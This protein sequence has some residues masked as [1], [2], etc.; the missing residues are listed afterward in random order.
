MCSNAN[1]K[2]ELEF[3]VLKKMLFTGFLLNIGTANPK[4]YP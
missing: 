3:G 4:L 1:P 2:I